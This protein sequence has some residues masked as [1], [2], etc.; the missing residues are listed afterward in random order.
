MR[1]FHSRNIG[2][3]RD[4]D[5]IPGRVERLPLNE[6]RR[7]EQEWGLHFVEGVNFLAIF[8]VICLGLF[9]GIGCGVGVAV[10][11]Q[12][13]SKGATLGGAVIA[14]VGVVATCGAVMSKI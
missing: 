7:Q 12:D 13:L 9:G 6:G 5:L 3:T 4:V 8:M 1:Y 2:S 14:V 10:I 11:Y